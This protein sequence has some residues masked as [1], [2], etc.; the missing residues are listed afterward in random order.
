M[1]PA[2]MAGVLSLAAC[3]GGGDGGTAV[4]TIA[5]VK[6]SLSMPSGPVASG[7][8]T[9]LTV[10]VVNTG[11]VAASGVSLGTTVPSSLSLN[12]VSCK[13][14]GAAACPVNPSGL[15]LNL[16]SLPA[17]G[18]VRFSLSVSVAGAT[19]GKVRVPTTLSSAGAASNGAAAVLRAF[20]PDGGVV[21]NAPAGPVVAGTD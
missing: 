13:A 7:S 17:G 6:V 3:G 2:V 19:S 1:W 20:A 15:N 14:S 21:A 5:D 12:G 11:T 8:Q 16:G 9:T 18:E 10:D 4:V